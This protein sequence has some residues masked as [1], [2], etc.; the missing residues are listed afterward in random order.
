MVLTT[1]YICS[2]AA[3]L[4]IHPLQFVS[5]FRLLNLI[6]GLTWLVLYDISLHTKNL[7]LYGKLSGITYRHLKLGK[8][9]LYFKNNYGT[10]AAVLFNLFIFNKLDK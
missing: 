5:V 10:S 4:S 3:F 6:L 1:T 2:S 8:S 7:L 9:F